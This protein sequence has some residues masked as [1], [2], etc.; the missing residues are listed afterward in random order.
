VEHLVKLIE[1]NVTGMDLKSAFSGEEFENALMNYLN[2]NF[3]D[4]IDNANLDSHVECWFESN[5]EYHVDDWIQNWMSYNFSLSD[6]DDGSIDVEGQVQN[7]I[8]S[9]CDSV[10]D[11]ALQLLDRARTSIERN[12][13][14]ESAWQSK[15][16]VILTRDEYDRIM[17]VVNFIRPQAEPEP[18]PPTNR[19]IVDGLVANMDVSELQAMITVSI[20]NKLKAQ[21]EAEAEAKAEAEAEAAKVRA[22]SE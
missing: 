14:I 16:S 3:H 11:Y 8:S 2:A 21:T 6:Y 7:W 22:E 17:E 5:A 15:A 1:V 12:V 20:S 9:G 4:W 19:E 10:D 18:Q 13:G